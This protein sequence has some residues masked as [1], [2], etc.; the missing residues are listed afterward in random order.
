MKFTLEDV[1]NNIFL[2]FRQATIFIFSFIALYTPVTV[3]LKPMGQRNFEPRL[4]FIIGLSMVIIIT[5]FFFPKLKLSTES[6][7]IILSYL[8]LLGISLVTVSAY[9]SN[10]MLFSMLLIA[11]LP[12]ILLSK[13]LHFLIYSGLMFL[14]YYSTIFTKA[15]SFNS[16]TGVISLGEASVN[17]KI[18]LLVV[19][20]IG[21]VLTIFIRRSII[22]I[23]NSL[24]ESLDAS[25]LLTQA[26][27]ENANRV[28]NSMKNTEVSFTQL[29]ESTH[30]LKENSSQIG[31]AVEEIAKGAMEQSGSLEAAMSSLNILGNDIDQLSQTIHHLVSG[32]TENE[33]LN[34]ENT[35][36]MNVLNS[37]L[38]DSVKINL[39]IVTAID[40]MLSEFSRIIDTIQNIDNIAGQTNLLAL[41]ASIESAR[42]GEAGRGFAVV[43]TEIRKLSEETSESA[44][45][46]NQIIASINHQ[47]DEVRSALGELNEQTDQTTDIVATTSKNIHRTLEYLKATGAALLDA[48]QLTKQLEMKKF[49]TNDCF[50]T[51][52]SVSEEYMAT[53]EEVSASISKIV[54]DIQRVAEDANQIKREL[55]KLIQ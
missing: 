25:E 49:E 47:I 30:S 52:A 45:G 35:K 10:V 14:V 34:E 8:F 18:T 11:F 17:V 39:K 55:T 44:K 3:L 41:N 28:I 16:A 43:A 5:V 38:E 23:F 33:S 6:K 24:G 31:L 9:P 20:I 37:T 29:S 15:S 2:T 21:F 4:Y 50:S 12:L 19:L 7:S 26:A 27:E 42:A 1:K 46:V 53:T 48:G 51:I 22:G 36:T 32:A 54:D 13:R 40:K